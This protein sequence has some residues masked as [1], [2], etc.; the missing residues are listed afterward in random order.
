MLSNTIQPSYGPRTYNI[1]TKA[2]GAQQAVTMGSF[3]DMVAK[4]S[5]EITSGAET[6]KVD[7]YMKHLES[8]YGKVT[9]EDVGR[10]RE[11][12][13][14]IGKR[15]S[16]NDVVIA[17]NILEDMANDPEKAA[18]FERKIDDFFD[19]TPRLKAHFAAQGLTYEPC[20]V[21]IHKDGSVT[22]I[23]GGGDSPE[24]VAEVNHINR[25]RDAKRAE[26]RKENYEQAVAAAELRRAM[27]ERAAQAKTLET[28][29]SHIGDPLKT[30]L[31]SIPAATPG[32]SLPAGANLFFF[33][34]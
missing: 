31:V 21:V 34:L 4:G 8:K 11:S 2:R 24:R 10:D 3:L 6:S 18:Y 29:F 16:G 9:I 27:W 14:K 13:E 30:Q 32:V 17:P 23:C 25:E 15:M 20:G 12:L 22:Y 5:T 28:P 7:A 1:P 19:A 33:N 26:R